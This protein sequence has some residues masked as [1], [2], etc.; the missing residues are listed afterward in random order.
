MIG[1]EKYDFSFTGLSLR[2]KDM[3]KVADALINELEFDAVNELGGGKSS[4][5]KKILN[6][7]NKRLSFLSK[8]ELRL[9]VF[10]DLATAKHVALLSM[11]KAHGFIRDF[12]VEVL[13]EKV[14]IF[15]YEL[16]EGEYI[17]FLRRKLESHPEL[18]GLT[19]LTHKKI[20]QVLFRS[21]EESGLIDNTKNREIQPQLLNDD[22]IKAVAS[23]NRQWLKV[24]LISDMDIEN[25]KI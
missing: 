14:L 5:T 18:Q 24:F 17:R 1:V 22:V 2:V 9:L 3:R 20:R 7:I 23:N 15:D 21:L 16:S 11:C 19:E 6:E 4:T 8:D 12:V 13:R 10:G 25:V